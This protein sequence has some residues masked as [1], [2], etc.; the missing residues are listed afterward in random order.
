MVYTLPLPTAT[1]YA[2]LSYTWTSGHSTT[3]WTA[4]Y[5]IV[6]FSS[7]YFDY[8]NNALNTSSSLV[9]AITGCM[10]P[11]SAPG[12]GTGGLVGASSGG[13]TYYASAIYA[14]QAALLAEQTANPGTKNAIIVVSDG[15]S[16]VVTGT[17]DFPSQGGSTLATGS[18][19]YTNLTG[20]GL[21]PDNHDECQQAIKA[22]N[23]ASA[24]GTR[25]YSVAYGSEASGCTGSGGTDNALLSS[26]I[27]KASL[28]VAMTSLSQITPCVAMENTAS[29]LTYFYSDYNQ[30]GSGSTCQDNSHPVVKL[31]DIFKAIAS[32]F[33]KPKLLPNNA[34]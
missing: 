10:S 6:G 11:I 19:G 29:S 25:V 16:N 20:T 9:K 12:S 8:A 7:D 21:Y 34:Q 23:D 18:S 27:Y 26:S 1:S 31:A 28:N 33:T 2:P 22:A 4:T 5:Q 14:A 32:D 17:H 13:I 24:A 15:Q 3:T 30:S